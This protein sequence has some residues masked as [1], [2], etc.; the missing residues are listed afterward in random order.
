MTLPRFSESLVVNNVALTLVGC[1]ALL[2]VL[3]FVLST[4]L[5]LVR[6]SARATRIRAVEDASEKLRRPLRSLA[7]VVSVC[8]VLLCL[9]GMAV[10]VFS[11]TDLHP[12]AERWAGHITPEGVLSATQIVL[13]VLGAIVFSLWLRRALRP[14]LPALERRLLATGAFVEEAAAIHGFVGQLPPLLNL[15]I[16][17]IGLQLV[18]WW[19]PVP[20]GLAWALDTL[21]Y[22]LFVL[23]VTRA[24]VFF[25]NLATEALDRL[26]RQRLEPTG[27]RP[28]Y[29]GVRGLWPLARRTFEAIAW[30]SAATLAVRQ[31]EALESF[32]PYGPHIIRLIAIF[33]VAR[34]VVELTRVLVAESLARKVDPRDEVAKRRAT[35]VYL[36]Q[37]ISK[38]VIYFG[39]VIMMLSELGIDPAPF[40]AGAGIVGLTLGLGAQKLV[41]DMVSGFFML[42]EGQLLTGDYIRIGDVEGTVAAVHLR[43]TE[44][45]DNDGRLHTLRNGNIEHI[46]N[47]SRDYVNAV[48][49][50]GIS[51]GTDLDRAWVAIQDA[52]AQL[53]A[54][55]PE[56]VLEDTVIAGVDKMA[57]YSIV[58][59]TVTRVQPGTHIQVARAF[60]RLVL[61][62]LV[63]HKVDIPFPTYTVIHQG[64]VQTTASTLPP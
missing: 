23:H 22:L 54:E 32:A 35:L 2:L 10:S 53:R 61:E 25:V 28:Y 18:E 17:Y 31:F 8:V 16:V 60:N 56:H 15:A 24:L 39:A 33:F 7:A 36:V 21:V 30:I 42:F 49:D 47:F 3:G 57:D 13:L 19:V 51:Y 45:R 38:Y 55:H 58:I 62:A 11:E 37:S 5:W 20:G 41:N 59:R 12:W 40:L 46:V 26:G 52:G 50:V 1:L 29:E 27:Y 43:V 44:I 9:V 34:V 6:R 4:A 63:R 14:A 48:V 64:P